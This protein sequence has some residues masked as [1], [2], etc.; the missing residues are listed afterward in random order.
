VTYKFDGKNMLTEPA[1]LF[2]FFLVVFSVAILIGRI[3][4][5]FNQK[6]SKVKS[7]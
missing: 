7:A 5:S 4:F 6:K 3:D 1:L 2:V